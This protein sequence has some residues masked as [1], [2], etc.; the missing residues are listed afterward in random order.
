MNSDPETVSLREAALS[1]GTSRQRLIQWIDDG[2]LVTETDGAGHRVTA[3]SVAAWNAARSEAG[4]HAVALV[5]AAHTGAVPAS[6]IMSAQTRAE[7]RM[8]NR[9]PTG[10]HRSHRERASHGEP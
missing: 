8:M 9:T 7:V 6:R 5:A 3:D 4:R 1:L 2:I 10:S